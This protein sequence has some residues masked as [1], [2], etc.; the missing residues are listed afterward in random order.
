MHAQQNVDA[1]HCMTPRVQVES[2]PSL[3]QRFDACRSRQAFLASDPQELVH[4]FNVG[5]R[6]SMAKARCS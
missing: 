3:L 1:S 5:K 4:V 2:T 6:N